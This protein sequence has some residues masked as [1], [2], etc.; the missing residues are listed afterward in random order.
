MYEG[1]SLFYKVFI[2]VLTLRFLFD[3]RILEQSYSESVHGQ[4]PSRKLN[5]AKLH[6]R[7]SQPG[8]QTNSL[9]PPL[10]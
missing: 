5:L 4:P 2:S 1:F 10:V 8:F 7:P 9:Y 6:T 3:R